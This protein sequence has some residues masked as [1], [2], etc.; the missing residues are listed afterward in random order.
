VIQRF[1]LD[2]RVREWGLAEHVVEKDFA[3]GWLLSGIGADPQ[4]GRAWI[5]KGGTC[6]KK[7]FVETWRFS[8]DLDFTVVPGGPIAPDAVLPI[9]RAILVRL[10]DASGIDFLAQ[11]PRL[12]PLA[13]GEAAE[14]SV[15]YRG[16]RQTPS[17]AR[18][19]LDLTRLEEIVLAPVERAIHHA[20][21]DSLPGRATVLCYAFEELFA[22]KI[23]ALADRLRP[24]DLYD[25]VNLLRNADLAPSE[26]GRAH[27]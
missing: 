24:R 8:E 17:A 4:L 15:Y 1:D 21:P 13:A 9:L 25:V 23:R 6:L 10:R 19:K 16:P 26:I 5:F 20:Y 14:G 2:Q 12:K 7:C 27:V 22:E 3:L 18:L 11:E